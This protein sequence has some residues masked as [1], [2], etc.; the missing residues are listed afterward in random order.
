[1]SRTSRKTERAMVLAPFALV[2]AMLAALPCQGQTLGDL[3][4]AQRLRQQAEI[5][6]LRKEAAAVDLEV[7]IPLKPEPAKPSEGEIRRA[8]EATRP[9]IVLHALYARNGVWIAELAQGQ[10]LALALVGMQLYGQRVTGIDQRGIALS[11]PC[12]A[13][14]VRDRVRC[15]ERVLRVGEAI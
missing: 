11:K 14:D 5:A 12:S 7:A 8:A 1:M 6:R 3:A 2:A 10:R 4:D 9:K 13:S 15:G